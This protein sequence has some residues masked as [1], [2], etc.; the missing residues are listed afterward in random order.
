LRFRLDKGPEENYL[1][2]TGQWYTTIMYG[3]CKEENCQDVLLKYDIFIWPVV[4]QDVPYI[5]A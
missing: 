2:V 4:S 3:L 5:K 1:G